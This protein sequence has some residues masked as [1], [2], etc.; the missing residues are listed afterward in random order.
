MA[1]QTITCTST[2]CER[3]QECRSPHECSG[4]AKEP[5]LFTQYK[6][7]HGRAFPVSIDVSPAIAE[8]AKKISARGLVFE[9]EHLT[10]GQVSLTIT[11]PN[12]GDLDI[13]LVNNGP[14]VRDAVEDL[15]A[16]FASPSA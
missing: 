16:N 9:C 8:Q 4:S 15:I 1:T 6:R 3:A 2:H 14:L 13:R 11:D 10:T 7:P 5:V 12:E